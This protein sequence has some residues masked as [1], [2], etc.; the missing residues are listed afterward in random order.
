MALKD[1]QLA[2]FDHETGTTRKL[3]ERIP[4]EKLAWTR[5]E[6]TMSAGG[7]DTHLSNIPSWGSLIMSESVFDLAN[8]PPNLAEKTSRADVL[9][10]FEQIIRA[11]RSALDKT[12]AELMAPWTL[13]RGGHEMFTMPRIAAFR[14]FV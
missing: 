8:A 2:E 13:K 1:G 7:L 5:H 12:D 14:S 10:H 4:D 3:L 9:A 11:T 6:R